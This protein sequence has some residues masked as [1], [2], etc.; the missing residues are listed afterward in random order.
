MSKFRKLYLDNSDIEIEEN[1]L[2]IKEMNDAFPEQSKDSFARSIRFAEKFLDT[3]KSSDD[4]DVILVVTHWD[5]VESF[6]GHYGKNSSK[7][8]IL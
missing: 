4:L 2:Y 3:L 7:I 6:S 8:I 5:I 1:D